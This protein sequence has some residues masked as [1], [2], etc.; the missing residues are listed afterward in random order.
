MTLSE[1]I[2]DFRAR[3]GITQNA[4][5]EGVSLSPTTIRK[6]ERGGYCRPTTAARIKMYMAQ[7]R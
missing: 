6:I 1:A 2:I 4:F 3:N 7:Y 5:A